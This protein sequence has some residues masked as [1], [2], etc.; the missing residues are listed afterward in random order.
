VLYQTIA[1]GRRA[2]GRQAFPLVDDRGRLRGPFNAML[3]SPPVGNA[4]QSVGSAV[5][6]ESVLSDRV[7]EMAILAVAS[8]WGSSFEREAHEAVSR[9]CGVEEQE[10]E[11]LATGIL[12]PLAD[13]LEATALRTTHALLAHG[14]LSD[15]EYR[16]AVDSIGE[17][18]LFELTTLVGYYGLLAL[19][20]RIFAGDDA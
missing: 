4:V 20:L 14:N 11:A 19:Q 7:R 3:L 5:R 8:H 16:Q 6:Y 15:A 9:T 10:L 13:P 2:N 17:R 18:G 1:G 12:P